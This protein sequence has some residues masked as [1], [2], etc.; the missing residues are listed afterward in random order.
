MPDFSPKYVLIIA[1]L[2][3]LFSCQKPSKAP[4]APEYSADPIASASPQTFPC[5]DSTLLTRR[6]VKL[7]TDTLLLPVGDSI[8]FF[9]DYPLYWE[10]RI[11]WT[12]PIITGDS[13]VD[14]VFRR[15]EK[16][17]LPRKG[18]LFGND[19]YDAFL[20]SDSFKTWAL[21]VGLVTVSK[22]GFVI[23]RIPLIRERMV[24]EL[25]VYL[26]QKFY[27]GKDSLISVKAFTASQKAEIM[28]LAG[29]D[30]YRILPD[31]VII[32]YFEKDGFHSH[33]DSVW[34]MNVKATG[35]VVNH[36]ANG[37]WVIIG[38]DLSMVY[39]DPEYYGHFYS[40][41]YVEGNY[42]HGRRDGI[43]KYFSVKK[44]TQ[45]YEGGVYYAIPT[46]EKGKKLLREE[47]YERGVLTR[48]TD[49]IKVADRVKM[50]LDFVR[51][52]PRF[53][54]NHGHPLTKYPQ[55][56]GYVNQHGGT[57]LWAI[58]NTTSVLSKVM[59]G[60]PVQ[61]LDD[62]LN[63]NQNWLYRDNVL[64][65]W[66]K[67]E[68]NGEL[69]FMPG[70]YL[71][72][73]PMPDS[74]E[75]LT[76][77]LA[78]YAARYPASVIFT[79]TSRQETY[80]FRQADIF[81]VYILLIATKPPVAQSNWNLAPPVLGKLFESTQQSPEIEFEIMEGYSDIPFSEDGKVNKLLK[82]TWHLT[83]TGKLKTIQMTQTGADVKVLIK[84]N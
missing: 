27:I 59:Y 28:G 22:S 56:S 43:W 3:G 78:E 34:L 79:K 23:D 18:W 45:L 61:I 4:S 52:A 10:P 9:F 32:P 12:D 31:G 68:Y 38:L 81:D 67:V 13:L 65:N 51:Y 20:V 25:D 11:E 19:C 24:D 83:Q 57:F 55:S 7:S 58:P 70:T 37:P 64:V 40:L 42:D 14:T 47:Y 80:L 71:S 84:S 29:F 53:I 39:G 73:L 66:L 2:A 26:T 60:E 17:N 6:F 76:L 54:R 33:P 35:E 48:Q 82:A 44:D 15:L 50:K 69:G 74:T 72:A 1:L 62:T 36:T 5:V 16:V 46:K 41:S 49:H 77:T 8:S 30:Q 75:Y 63:L 21:D